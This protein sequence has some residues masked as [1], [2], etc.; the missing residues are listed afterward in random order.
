ML[1]MTMA[2]RLQPECAIDQKDHVGNEMCFA[3]FRENISVSA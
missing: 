1:A 2:G 3:E